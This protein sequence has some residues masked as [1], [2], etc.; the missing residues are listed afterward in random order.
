MNDNLT[1]A[2]V[3]YL[4]IR[5]CALAY[6]CH[7]NINAVFFRYFFLFYTIVAL[8]LPLVIVI[9]CYIPIFVV[10]HRAN[11][12]GNLVTILAIITRSSTLEYL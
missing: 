6:L 10:S 1:L 2:S 8:V 3:A 11:K 5:H 9:A 12:V 7:Y 4:L